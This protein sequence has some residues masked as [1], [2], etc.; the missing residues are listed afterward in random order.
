MEPSNDMTSSHSA[1]DKTL[2]LSEAS[3]IESIESE[4]AQYRSR[5]NEGLE[6]TFEGIFATAIAVREAIDLINTT[7]KDNGDEEVKKQ[8]DEFFKSTNLVNNPS[9]KSK[10]L[11]IANRI[12]T[13]KKYK[14]H[15]PHNYTA[16]YLLASSEKSDE[17]IAKLTKNKDEN[18]KLKNTLTIKQLTNLIKRGDITKDAEKIENQPTLIQIQFSGE[19]LKDSKII[20]FFNKHADEL[21]KGF[22]ET[23]HNVRKSHNTEIPESTKLEDLIR[24]ELS[25]RVKNYKPKK[26]SK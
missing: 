16:Y 8:R 19:N 23:I 21:N 4:L 1:N 18:K 15:I 2:T 25:N 14:D 13:L 12:D 26:K 6:K 11:T 3:N 7:F 5:I 20:D 22:L 10:L 9:D 17:E 24:I